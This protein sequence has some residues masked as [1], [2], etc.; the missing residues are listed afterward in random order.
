MLDPGSVSCSLG[1][2][3]QFQLNALP[4]GQGAVY[5]IDWGD[6]SQDTGI[7]T[8]TVTHTFLS[9]G[10]Y[11]VTMTAD[12]Q[13]NNVQGSTNITIYDKIQGDCDFRCTDHSVFIMAVYMHLCCLNKISKLRKY[14]IKVHFYFLYLYSVYG[15][16]WFNVT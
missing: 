2:F 8:S 11:A 6:G 4:S 1:S 14:Q 7:S 15:F 13:I 9:R 16:L 10:M 12:N 3:L 5:T